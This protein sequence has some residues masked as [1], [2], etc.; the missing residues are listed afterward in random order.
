M[1]EYHFNTEAARLYGVN[2]AIFLHSLAFWVE[3]NRANGKH[4]HD[5]RYWTYNTQEAFAELFPF[6]TKRQIERII[7]SCNDQKAILI[8]NFNSD[9]TNRTKWYA[10]TDAAMNIYFPK[11]VECISPN[12]EMAVAQ[13]VDGTEEAPT[14]ISPN[15]EMQ[16]TKWC[17][18][19]HQTVKCNKGNSCLPDSKPPISPKGE[20]GEKKLPLSKDV[21]D[22]LNGYVGQDS[23]L[24]Q[25]LAELMRNRISLKA[26]ND[27]PSVK[28]LLN[29]LDKLSGDDRQTKLELLDDAIQSS[30][31]T[32]YEPRGA[33]AAKTAAP[34]RVVEY[35]EVPTW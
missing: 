27:A 31:K 35:G 17:D 3:K 9:K 19:S 24:A 4:L 10:L 8:D 16:I 32:V 26:I 25:A 22:M 23:E 28:R 30:W 34:A 18:P 11:T 20:E 15:G 5:G 21:R 1:N 29:R 12:G 6:W 2:E 7:A 14:P 13:E 33:K